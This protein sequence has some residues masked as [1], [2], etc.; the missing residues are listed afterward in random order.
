MLAMVFRDTPFPLDWIFV[1]DIV[2]AVIGLFCVTGLSIFFGREGG[3]ELRIY[4]L[5]LMLA[6]CVIDQAN[7]TLSLAIAGCTIAGMMLGI[8][9]KKLA[10][11]VPEPTIDFPEKF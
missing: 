5:A 6:L 9:W 10:S 2:A 3:N 7:T 4:Y 1:L 11:M 8:I